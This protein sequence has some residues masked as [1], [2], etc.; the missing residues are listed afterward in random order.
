MTNVLK[1]RFSVIPLKLQYHPYAHENTKDSQ[2][3][4]TTMN[5]EGLP[6]LHVSYTVELFLQQNKA[7]A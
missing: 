5:A 6:Y 1:H 7:K 2:Q 3:S 4:Q